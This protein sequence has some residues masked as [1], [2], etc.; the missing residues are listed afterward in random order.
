[1]HSPPWLVCCIYG[2]P[3]PVC[4]IHSP[5]WLVCCIYGPPWL[6]CC[7]YWPSWL[8]CCVHGP[9]H[10][11]QK[12][13]G[14][15]CRWVLEHISAEKLLQRSGD[16][17]NS[18]FTEVGGGAYIWCGWVGAGTAQGPGW[19]SGGQEEVGEGGECSPIRR[20]GGRSP[21]PPCGRCPARHA[22]CLGFVWCL[23]PHAEH[24]PT[25]WHH[26]DVAVG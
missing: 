1:M 11:W 8:V 12:F 15:P 7:I 3:W 19:V 23:V 5:P 21:G 16:R 20:R 10:R 4:C 18:N 22:A 25:A 9:P 17:K 6:D 26:A 2:P 13:W 24:T 14:L